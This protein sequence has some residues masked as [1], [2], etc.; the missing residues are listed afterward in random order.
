MWLLTASVVLRDNSACAG[1]CF[2]AFIPWEMERGWSAVDQC[3]AEAGA[4]GILQQE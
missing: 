2:V 1:C 3:R 4:F